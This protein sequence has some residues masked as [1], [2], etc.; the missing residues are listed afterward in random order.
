MSGVGDG[1]GLSTGGG[2]ASPSSGTA[3]PRGEYVGVLGVGVGVAFGSGVGV[4][5]WTG[6]VRRGR[7]SPGCC[8]RPAIATVSNSSAMIVA[9][10]DIAVH[11]RE[12]VPVKVVHFIL[13]MI[14]NE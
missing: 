8:A 7:E 4:A 12:I 13:Q 11:R 10:A 6:S 1:F 3:T 9:A 5:C 2:G 14:L